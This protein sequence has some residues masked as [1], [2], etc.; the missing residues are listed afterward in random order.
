M[1]GARRLH[2]AGQSLWLDTISRRLLSSGTLA[3]YIADYALSGLTSNPTILGHAMVAGQDYD[4]SIRAQ[5][6]RGVGDPQEIVYA[7]ALED[8]QEAADLFQPAWDATGGQDGWVS[9]EVPPELAEDVE[10]TIAVARSL[11]ERARPNLFVK[12]PGTPAGLVATEELIAAGVPINVTLLFS[13]AHYR[14]TAEAYMRALERRLAAGAPLDVHSVASLFVSRWDTNADPLLPPELHGRLGVAMAQLAYAAH[15]ELLASERW[16]RVAAAGAPPQRLL[17]ASTSTKD[18][19]L[20][21]TFYVGRLATPGTINTMPEKT[22]LAFAEHGEV[23]PFLAADRVAGE[24][25][26]A[27]I[28]RH[29]VDPQ[30]LGESLQRQGARAFVADWEHLLAAVEEKAARLATVA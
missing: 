6:A 24:T 25:A 1:N 19:A 7:C 22:L 26:L 4:A 14:A 9:L 15:Q 28:A 8:L 5:T 2:E 10:R 20:P 3:R 18:P 23:G 16:R 12:V 17:W 13:E 27:T 21:D 30:A 29:G 11:H